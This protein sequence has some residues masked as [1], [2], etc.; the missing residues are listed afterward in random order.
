MAEPLEDLKRL[1]FEGRLTSVVEWLKHKIELQLLNSEEELWVENHPELLPLKNNL[2]KEADGTYRPDSALTLVR[3][4]L[5]LS[6]A[7]RSIDSKKITLEEVVEL[8]KNC[9][10]AQIYTLGVSYFQL[11]SREQEALQQSILKNS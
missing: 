9:T 4:R 8:L 6:R 2:V 11:V 1:V 7:I 5:I 3:T 10:S